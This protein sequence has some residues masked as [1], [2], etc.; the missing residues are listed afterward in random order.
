MDYNS[1]MII[2][3][4]IPYYVQ[5]QCILCTSISEMM[6]IVKLN[7]IHIDMTFRIKGCCSFYTVYYVQRKSMVELGGFTEHL[8]Y[9]LCSTNVL[10]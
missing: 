9:M 10:S 8:S 4:Q 2:T 3:H 7:V 1:L 5:H 6:T